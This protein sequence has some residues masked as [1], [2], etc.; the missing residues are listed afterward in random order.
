M[1]P[2]RIHELSRSAFFSKPSRYECPP[3]DKKQRFPQHHLTGPFAQFPSS[4]DKVV[5]S[6]PSYVFS[7]SS[8]SC[9]SS[10][11]VRLCAR[12]V[13]FSLYM[14]LL[15]CGVLQQTVPIAARLGW[16]LLL[17]TIPTV[18]ICVGLYVVLLAQFIVIHDED[19]A[20]SC[21]GEVH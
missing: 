1:Q 4:F 16:H 14:P 20:S 17:R 13:F 10:C 8:S 2:T 15:H 7:V 3:Q 19:L 21:L 5:H 6:R 18:L 12:R 9:F 11:R